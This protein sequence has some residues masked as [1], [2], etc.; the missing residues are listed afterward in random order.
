M[1]DLT[2]YRAG[3]LTVVSRASTNRAG[4]ATWLCKCDCGKEKVVSS[5][6]LTRLK[7]SV[8][9]CGCLRYRSGPNHK[10][11]NGFK[12][13]SGGWWF[14]HVLRERT[15]N[16]RARVPVTITKEEAWALYEKQEACCALTGM[17][18]VISS[19]AETNTASIDRIDSSRGY[20]PGNVQWVHKHINF[21]KR[22]YDQ[23][24]F[25][26]MC[27]KVAEHANKVAL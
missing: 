7:K 13:I 14:T 25:I 5:D 18:I 9:S 10:Q 19:N 12:G 4:L 11:F 16:T 22:T 23:K 15:Q 1:K 8:K 26:R 6:H 21:M 3:K 2:G 20:E 24:Y 27:S 17:A